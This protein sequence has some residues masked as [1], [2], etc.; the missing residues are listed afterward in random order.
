ML[1]GQSLLS[2]LLRRWRNLHD[3]NWGER[4]VDLCLRL[5]KVLI[6]GLLVFASLDIELICLRESLIDNRETTNLRL[7]LLLSWLLMVVLFVK[8]E[9]L[10]LMLVLMHLALVES[11]HDLIGLKL[12]LVL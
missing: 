7:S 5:S 6:H 4:L 2:R 1:V 8:V 12:P 11:V 3:S 10:G 9:I